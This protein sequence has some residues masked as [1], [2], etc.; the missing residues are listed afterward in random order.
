MEESHLGSSTTYGDWRDQLVS[1]GYVVVKGVLTLERAQSYVDR[2]MGWLESFPFGFDR[3]RK[4]TWTAEHLPPNLKF[5][6]FDIGR[7]WWD[8]MRTDMCTLGEECTKATRS[9]MRS[10]CGM[11][12]STFISFLILL[13]L[14]K[15]KRAI[16]PLHLLPNLG[17][18][19][20][21]RLLRRHKPHPPG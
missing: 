21:P 10:S 12:D 9:S 8:G 17:Y 15:P 3:D 7:V 4:S 13:T 14:T 5:V 11:Q 19:R 1:D 6:P 16:H 2:M 20:P 18:P